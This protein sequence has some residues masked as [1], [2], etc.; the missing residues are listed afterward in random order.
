MKIFS[1]IQVNLRW[2]VTRYKFTI[3]IW[4]SQ[5][6][7]ILSFDVHLNILE[8]RLFS[9][10]L[11]CCCAFLTLANSAATL[12]SLGSSS[13]TRAR[14]WT[15]SS[16]SWRPKRACARRK[17]ALTLFGSISITLSH[18]ANVSSQCLKK[19]LLFYTKWKI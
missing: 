11:Y 8:Y 9:F 5:T 10:S 12:L 18:T 17:R 7:G 19:Q 6:C 15:A 2:K 13:L 16:K 3:G 4:K 1:Q 14:S